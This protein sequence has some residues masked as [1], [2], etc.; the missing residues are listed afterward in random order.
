MMVLANR[1]TERSDF[2]LS[3]REVPDARVPAASSKLQRIQHDWSYWTVPQKR[4]YDREIAWTKIKML[5]GCSSGECYD[6]SSGCSGDYDEWA[7]L[8]TGAEG[9]DGGR[10][11]GSKSEFYSGGHSREEAKWTC[12]GTCKNSK[13]SFLALKSLAQR[14]REAKLDLRR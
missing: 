3:G 4:C 12:K 7:E 14:T 1:S 2:K 8:Q 10:I 9:A 13:R 5:G 11:R 6:V